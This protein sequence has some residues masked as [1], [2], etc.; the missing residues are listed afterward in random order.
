VQKYQSPKNSPTNFF[1]G[2]KKQPKNSTSV[3]L[4][5]A[6]SKQMLKIE[7]NG[8]VKST[9]GVGVM[10]TIFCDIRQFSTKNSVILKNQCYDQIFA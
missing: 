8:F 5:S 3:I 1:R 4:K 2:E 10:I 9:P 7:K 6:Q